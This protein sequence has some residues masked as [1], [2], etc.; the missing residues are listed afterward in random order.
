[1]VVVSSHIC[2]HHPTLRRRTHRS[3]QGVHNGVGRS[4]LYSARSLPAII[5]TGRDLGTREMVEGKRKSNYILVEER[6]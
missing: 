3:R 2:L 5:V 6:L 1:M 4:L